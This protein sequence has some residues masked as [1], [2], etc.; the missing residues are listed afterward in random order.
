[1]GRE[2][3]SVFLVFFALCRR[4]E[5]DKENLF[6]SLL[7]FLLPFPYTQHQI[8]RL[9]HSSLTREEFAFSSALG[10]YQWPCGVFLL[11]TSPKSSL[12]ADECRNFVINSTTLPSP[13]SPPRCC[14]LRVGLA[15]RSPRCS[16]SRC[17]ALSFHR[18]R[19]SGGLL[20]CV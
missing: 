7:S 13:S 20:V 3:I 1:M 19:V 14:L 15:D 4:R 11:S 18:S 17:G 16:V 10:F 8:L 9:L 5:K 12:E 6:R 2:V